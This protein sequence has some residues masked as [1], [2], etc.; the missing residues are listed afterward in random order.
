L[1]VG[2]VL[3]HPLGIAIPVVLTLTVTSPFFGR[4]HAGAMSIDRKCGTTSH[5]S[6]NILC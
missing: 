3:T 4:R 2:R 5:I 6:N 1:L